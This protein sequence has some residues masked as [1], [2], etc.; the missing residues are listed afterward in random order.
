MDRIPLTVT[1]DLQLL[2]R[3]FKTLLTEHKPAVAIRKKGHSIER[4]G[5]TKE[6]R[7]SP[8]AW[9]FQSDVTRIPVAAAVRRQPMQWRQTS[10]RTGTS[11]AP[12]ALR[13]PN[14]RWGLRSRRRRPRRLRRRCRRRR[15]EGTATGKGIPGE[16][17]DSLQSMAKS[18]AGKTCVCLVE[19]DRETAEKES[20]PRV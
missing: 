12:T 1:A 15:G 7:G 9:L 20:A 10:A 2:C 11:P 5:G 17:E 16:K 4:R 3:S 13:L 6:A 19:R 14:R 18:G 8:R